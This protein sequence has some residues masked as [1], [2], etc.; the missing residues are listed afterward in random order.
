MQ[1]GDL[2]FLTLEYHTLY[3]YLLLILTVSNVMMFHDILTR[4]C[5]CPD[6]GL[7]G[8]LGDLR[9]QVVVLHSKQK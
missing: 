4:I 5:L 3:F 6:L 8:S 7:P 2:D 1:D 9:G